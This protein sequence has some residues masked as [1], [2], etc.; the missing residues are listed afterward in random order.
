MTAEWTPPSISQE[1]LITIAETTQVFFMNRK[2]KSILALVLCFAMSSALV[3]Q[4]VPMSA[5]AV[6]QAEI[7]A[8]KAQ[9][10]AIQAQRE[11]K[12]AVALCPWNSPGK[13]TGVG[14]HFLLQGIFLSQGS[15]L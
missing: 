4:S 12:Q 1:F 3:L 5:A 14:C 8:L 9:R 15:N 7:D 6:T 10:D 13:N 11:E 2:I